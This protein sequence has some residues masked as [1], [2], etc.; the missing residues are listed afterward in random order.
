MQ[1]LTQCPESSI[2]E[3]V[4]NMS[5]NQSALSS[6]F[7]VAPLSW[8]HFAICRFWMIITAL[9]LRF[10]TAPLGLSLFVVSGLTGKSILRISAR[11]TPFVFFML[12][13]VILIACIPA[14]STT[15]LPDF[16]K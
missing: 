14:L 10:V 13:V 4:M 8:V 1:A 12:F 2:N 11:A 6:R 5:L 15:L 9:G 16:Y 3:L 7:S